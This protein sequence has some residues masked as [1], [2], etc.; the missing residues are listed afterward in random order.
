MSV[1]KRTWKTASGEAKEAWVVVYAVDGKRHHRT[2]DR[3][4]DADKFSDNMKV[5]V[6]NGVHTPDRESI[7][8]TEAG[9]LW[10]KAATAAGLERS[11]I[12]QYEDHLEHHI[13]PYLGR[14]RLSRLSAPM[15][16]EFED[17][18]AAGTPPPGELTGRPRSSAMVRKVRGSL[19]SILADA[20]ERG[21]VARNVVRE[22]RIGRRKRGTEQRGNK[23]KVGVDIPTPDEVRKILA[24]ATP[25]RWRTLLLVAVFC[26]LRSSEL[27][28]L[29]WTDVDLAK[30]EL[31]VRQRA[32]KYNVIGKPKSEAGERTI[33]IPSKVLAELREWKL[34]CPYSELGLAFPTRAGK[35]LTHVS[36]IRHGV[37]PAVTAAGVTVRTGRTKDGH[38]ILEPKYAGLHSFRH[39]FASWCINREVDGGCELPAKIVQERL[40]HATIGM[41][42]DRYGHLFPR[43]DDTAEL[44]AAAST[45][46]G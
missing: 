12:D 14:V 35:I 43:G 37:I 40:G 20:Q 24:L 27:R 21:L 42:L 13:S 16:R 46:L 4:K 2:F 25:G 45:L 34:Q 22:L 44:D 32:D 5:E 8:V 11:T 1:R 29:R 31:H 18:L 3:K 26:G 41:T 23:L 28:G 30:G 9:K 19:G 15:V 39:F 33:P 36:I 38:P 7:T 10:I 6:R 17:R